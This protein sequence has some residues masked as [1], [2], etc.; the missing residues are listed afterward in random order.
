MIDQRGIVLNSLEKTDR[1]KNF[2]TPFGDD[3][4][5]IFQNNSGDVTLANQSEKEIKKHR[6]HLEDLVE[7]R[8]AEIVDAEK[9]AEEANK[10]KSDFLTSKTMKSGLQ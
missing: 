10:A 6:D 3:L 8:T 7:E 1:F 9:A 5:S 4:V 2:L